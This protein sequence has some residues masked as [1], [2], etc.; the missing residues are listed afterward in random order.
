VDGSHQSLNEHFSTPRES[1]R[2][3]ILFHHQ[4]HG[5]SRRYEKDESEE[6]VKSRGGD[7]YDWM[8][9]ADGCLATWATPISLSVDRSGEVDAIRLPDHRIEYLKYEGEVSGN[10]G[11][12]QRVE[13]GRFKLTDA[14][15]DRYEIRT[16]GKREGVFVIYRTWCADGASF[17]RISFRCSAEG[18]PTR[19]DA[20]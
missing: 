6:S 13:E 12:V 19:A 18:M 11:S 17:W 1:G 5:A 2:Y 20:S 9:E 16:F 10:R 7:H 3:V 8:F 14:R 4:P 15:P